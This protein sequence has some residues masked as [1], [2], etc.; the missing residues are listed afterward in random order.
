MALNRE[1]RDNCGR[2][3]PEELGLWKGA[4]GGQPT[5]R[6]GGRGGGSIG[7]E[8]SRVAVEPL[9]SEAVKAEESSAT[10]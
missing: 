1:D 7:F 5:G 3:G 6:S 10:F 2:S 8:E 9:P 4:L